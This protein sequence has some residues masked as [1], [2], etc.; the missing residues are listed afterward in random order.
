MSG[1][2]NGLQARIQRQAP[3]A[4]FVPCSAHSLNLV[5]TATAESCTEACRFF[6]LLQEHTTQQVVKQ[7]T[8]T[9]I[10]EIFNAN[11]NRVPRTSENLISCYRNMKSKTKKQHSD[12]KMALTG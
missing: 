5:A 12:A 7:E 9:R 3:F 10:T 6:M 11:S 1:I 2:Y 8:W 4:F